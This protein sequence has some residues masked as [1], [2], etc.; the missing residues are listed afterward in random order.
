M[1]KADIEAAKKLELIELNNYWR[2]AGQ[3]EME[4]DWL[5]DWILV[6]ATFVRHLQRV[7]DNKKVG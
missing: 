1:S 2:R 3:V 6:L 5:H 7:Y 4:L